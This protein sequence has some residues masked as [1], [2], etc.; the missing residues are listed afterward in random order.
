[1]VR[2]FLVYFLIFAAAL[3]CSQNAA[4][5]WYFGNGAA[6]NFNSGMP[7]LQA[8]CAIT[9]SMGCSSISDASGN[10]LFYTDG[11]NVYNQMNAVMANGG[12]L[13]GSNAF[14]SALI[15]KQ[16]GTSTLYYVFTVGALG[17][18]NGLYYSVVD[19]A[20]AT[21]MGSVTIKNVL[22]HSDCRDKLSAGLHCNG[23]DVWIVSAAYSSTAAFVACAVSATGVGAPVITPTSTAVMPVLGIGQI[24]ISP[25]SH[26]LGVVSY[27]AP[28]TSCSID[29]RIF[30]FDN[31]NGI[32]LS[33]N[34]ATV[35]YY[36]YGGSSANC[37]NT[38]YGCEFSQDSRY[39]YT[40]YV[41]QISRIDLCSLPIISNGLLPNIENFNVYDTTSKRSMQLATDGRIYVA[42]NGKASLGAINTPTSLFTASYSSMAIS[43]NTYTC[44]W[45]L[46]NIPGYLFEQK[47]LPTFSYSLTSGNCLTAFFNPNPV[48]ASSGYSISSYQWNFGEPSSG[49]AN[50]S[51]Q[52]NP[53][54]F[55]SAP[56]TYSVTMI[57]YFLCNGSDTLRQ[58]LNV[59]APVIAIVNSPSVCYASSATVQVNAA[60]NAMNYLWSP[61]SQTTA[62][63]N[64]T[65]SGIY[66]VTVTDPGN[67]YCTVSA[68]TAVQVVSLTSSAIVS[69]VICAGAA[70]GAA[71]L[72]VAGGSGSYQYFWSGSAASSSIA[73]QLSG[74]AYSIT[75]LDNS[76]LCTHSAVVTVL[77]PP[78]L[79]L[80]LGGGTATCVN[81]NINLTSISSGGVPPY[82]VMWPGIGPGQNVWTSQ[83]LSGNYIY[84]CNVLDANTCVNSKTTSVQFLPTPSLSLGSG[85]LC[86][87][88]NLTL[89]ANG[90]SSYSWSI[91]STLNP[92]ILL[93]PPS[94]TIGL[95][96]QLGPCISSTVAVIQNFPLPF[97]SVL[98]TLPVCVGASLALVANGT[99]TFVWSGPAS[100]SAGTSSIVISNSALQNS[101]SYSVSL[102]DINLCQSTQTLLANVLALPILSISPSTNICSGET[103]TLTVM[104]AGTYTW[105]SGQ[106]GNTIVITPF[107]NTQYSVTGVNL[108]TGCEASASVQVIVNRCSGISEV[109]KSLSTQVY[110]VPAGDFLY[111]DKMGNA[112]Y[113]IFTSNSLLVATGEMVSGKNI[114]DLRQLS[115]GFYLLEINANGILERKKFIKE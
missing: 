88:S 107:F 100:F 97:L 80:S 35:M 92:I 9:T 79:Q 43:L 39:L 18:G 90:A 1:M 95:Q 53:V 11:V 106:T 50:T 2:T 51:F 48:C 70:T 14:Q 33:N 67:G 101:G 102:T 73:S 103:T 85:T 86:S 40:S 110:P 57:R 30:N 37:A 3:L 4:K 21:G 47:P 31:T 19:M 72:I 74:G 65:S 7:V 5:R 27:A 42:K 89:S 77:Q 99:G 25:N 29:V 15:I 54:H 91:G 28:G 64:F 111:V 96:G 38:F 75:V 23:G 36:T 78:V 13:P 44:Q 12:G 59:T 105:A 58:V 41:N 20:L 60:S 46:P 94:G 98:P 76:F 87:G 8:G 82:T 63:A 6:L 61:G 112:L 68:T 115:P 62:I 32:V 104:G 56:G 16:P 24:K 84:T 109:N 17:S 71:S 10:T 52:S 81:Q 55:Y 45:G 108:Q 83:A 26:K 34:V 22:L 49:A 93:S 113:Q 114:I 66:T 69:S